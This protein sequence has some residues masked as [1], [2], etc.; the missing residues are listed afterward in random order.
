MTQSARTRSPV[1][2][3]SRWAKIARERLARRGAA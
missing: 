1:E 2:S 3:E